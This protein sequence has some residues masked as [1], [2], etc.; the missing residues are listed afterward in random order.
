MF[1]LKKIIIYIINILNLFRFWF[2][3]IVRLIKNIKSY[4]IYQV[5]VL[6]NTNSFINFFF[7][8]FS[9][10]YWLFYLFLIFILISVYQFELIL[11]WSP[12]HVVLGLHECISNGDAISFLN[13]YS[14]DDGYLF[15]D[16]YKQY[17]DQ[18]LKNLPGILTSYS[19]IKYRKYIRKYR[20]VKAAK[21]MRRQAMQPSLDTK[22]GIF[23]I[24]L[25]RFKYS[26]K[27]PLLYP[28]KVWFKNDVRLLKSLGKSRS[29]MLM[30]WNRKLREERRNSLYEDS[31]TESL[32]RR[33]SFKSVLKQLLLQNARSFN[34]S[35]KFYK[36]KRR[37]K[38]SKYH[39]YV[40]SLQLRR[41][42]FKSR[43]RHR[44]KKKNL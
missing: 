6:C 43:L 30:I 32:I 4:F 31:Y 17:Y 26:K 15:I 16:M 29:K 23:F 18:K 35:K 39:K 19:L 37:R 12:E 28:K 1:F 2:L 24:R 33:P 40:R 9:Y 42:I 21:L 13:T 41:F 22:I 27:S 5:S 11:M 44:L 20:L 7:N 10:N 36:L 14:D 34:V 3:K 8:F 38:L 25:V